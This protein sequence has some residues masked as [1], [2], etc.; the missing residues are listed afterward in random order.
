MFDL[1]GQAIAVSA[2]GCQEYIR[3]KYLPH[4]LQML[5]QGIRHAHHTVR[6]AALYMLGQEWGEIIYIYIYF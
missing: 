4:M 3:T 1:S 5:G 2:E 6:N